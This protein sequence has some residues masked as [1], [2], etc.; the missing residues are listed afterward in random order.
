MNTDCHWENKTE[1]FFL[2]NWNFRPYRLKLNAC[3]NK[4]FSFNVAFSNQGFCET[5]A[6]LAPLKSKQQ[7]FYIPFSFN[8]KINYKQVLTSMSD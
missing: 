8:C 1:E 6:M 2:K 5:Y 3:P 4:M 7:N